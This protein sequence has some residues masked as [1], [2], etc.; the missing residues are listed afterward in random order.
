MAFGETGTEA[1]RKEN[2][3]ALVKGFALQNFTMKQLVMTP[4]STAWSESY[5]RESSTELTATKGIPR[6]AGFPHQSPEWEKQTAYMQKHGLEV[7]VSLEDERMNNLDV[8]A[9]SLLRIPRAI[10][11]S[12]DDEIWDKLSESQ[13]PSAI[14]EV[15]VA[16]GNTWDNATRANRLPHDDIGQA[17]QKLAEENYNADFI[18]VNPK[19]FRLLITNDNVLDAFAPADNIMKSGMM[20]TLMGLKMIVSNSITADNALV[21]QSKICGTYRV[22]QQLQTAVEEKAGISKVIRS[23]EIGAAF[24]TDPKALCLITNT[25]S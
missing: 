11:K 9:R 7:E 16:G 24:V 2:V 1:L 4:S 19:D 21:G 14:Q 23:W 20:G 6:L 15:A 17:V 5:Y 25:N 22:A 18:A 10:V 13:S 12:V 8:I 3:D